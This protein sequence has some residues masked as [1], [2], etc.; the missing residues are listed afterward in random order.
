MNHFQYIADEL[1][2]EEVPVSKIA[3][4][5]GTPLYLYSHA[6]LRHHFRVFDDAFSG[7][8]HLT[9]FSIKVNSNLTLLRLFAL[10]GGGMDIVSGGELYR[11]LKA[12]VEPAK[13]VYS[14]VGKRVEDIE[15][16][17]KSNIL[18][19]NVESAQ[20]ILKLNEVAAKIGKKAKM[21]IR[22]NPD[23]DPETH[24]YISTGLRENKFGIDI[25][26]AF[27]QYITAA[28]MDNLKVVGVSCHIGSQLTLASPFVDALKKLKQI[29]KRLKKEE[30][31][32]DYLNLGGGLG[33]TY[34]E[35]KPPGPK[36]YANAISKELE[37]LDLMLILEPGRVITGNAGILVTKVLYTKPTQKKTFFIVDAAMNDLI[38]PSLYNS[39]HGIQPVRIFQREKVKADIVGPVCESTD[40]FAKEREVPFFEAGELMAIMSAGAYAFSMSSNYNSRPR[41]CEVMVKGNRFYTIKDRETFEDL[42]KGEIIPDF[43]MRNQ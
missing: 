26:N 2:C 34:N 31:N 30:I 40:F 25:N 32:I 8:K 5:V 24:P 16:A 3:E 21:A 33:I 43:L 14:G 17:L 27:E 35:E 22:V 12:G 7:M 6:T 20:E 18:M 37:A 19:F 10:E 23:V 4:E 38:R 41:V 9:C 1:Y 15:Y 28:G 11:A 29:I 39:Y 42:V 13:I 36:E